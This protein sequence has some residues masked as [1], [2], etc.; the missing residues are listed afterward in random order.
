MTM[1]LLADDNVAICCAMCLNGGCVL[2]SANG[3][4][5]AIFLSANC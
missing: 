2:A 4:A 1:G 3:L 5:G